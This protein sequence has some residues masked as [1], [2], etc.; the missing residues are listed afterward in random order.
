MTKINNKINTENKSQRVIG[1]KISM[2][3][4]SS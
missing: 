4:E 1:R 3:S 2:F